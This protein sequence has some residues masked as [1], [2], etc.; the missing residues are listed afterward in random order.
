MLSSFLAGGEKDPDRIW[1]MKFAE[2][3]LHREAH[4]L[5]FLAAG[6]TMVSEGLKTLQSPFV[7]ISAANKVSQFILTTANPLNWFPDDDDLIKSGRYE[8]HGHIYKRF[9]ELPVTGIAQ[10]NQLDK[11]IEDLDASSLFYTRDYR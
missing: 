7:A 5:G 8:G 6:P 10:W 9:M 3:M 11:L 2:Y 1:A 4:E